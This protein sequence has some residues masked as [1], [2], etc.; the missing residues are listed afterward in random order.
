VDQGVLRNLR[1]TALV[2]RALTSSRE[3]WL[4]DVNVPLLLV[5]VD[6]P[7][8]EL[9]LGL[10]GRRIE[11]RD[12][13][14]PALAFNTVSTEGITRRPKSIP[15]PPSLAPAQLIV[16]IVRACHVIVA[17]GKRED[18]GR[19][20]SERVTVGR[21]RNSDVV[22][23]H[24]SVSK[25]H[26]WFARDER[27]GY[28]VADASSR[29]GTWHNGISLPG[30]APVRVHE[31]DVIRFGSVEATYCEPATLYGAIRA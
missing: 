15:P 29:N 13:G 9:A 14:E 3:E 17:V 31:G 4:R 18:A 6:D 11:A 12:R 7:D 10:Q 2:E 16:R 28:Y 1:P 5:K 19:V 20:F 21:A 30:G 8:G 25:F 23:R 27:N 26:A 22:L 24:E